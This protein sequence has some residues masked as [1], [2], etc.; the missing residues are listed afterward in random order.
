MDR[1]KI[2]LLWSVSLI[3]V[4]VISLTVLV[5]KFLW[6]DISAAVTVILGVTE[7]IGIAVLVYT[8]FKKF[9]K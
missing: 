1:K 8:T 3:V 7:L 2:D 5:L 4:N 6:I 9:K